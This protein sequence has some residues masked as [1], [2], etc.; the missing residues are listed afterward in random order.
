GTSAIDVWVFTFERAVTVT[1]Q[2]IS[3]KQKAIKSC[4]MNT[5]KSVFVPLGEILMKITAYG[6]KANRIAPSAY[7]KTESEA[8]ARA[9]HLPIRFTVASGPPLNNVRMSPALTL[10]QR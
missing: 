3:E 6:I 2:P 10:D 4:A 5:A 7:V 8:K 9:S 1:I